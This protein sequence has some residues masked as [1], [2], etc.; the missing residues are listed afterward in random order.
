MTDEMTEAV[1]DCIVIGA[2]Y[3]GLSASKT[4]EEDGKSILLLEANERVGGR[5]WT[6]THEDGSWEDYGGA[7]LGVKQPL[8]YEL[9]SEFGITT[10]DVPTKGKSILHYR[11]KTRTQDP[12]GVPPMPAL[13]LV[14]ALLTLSKFNKLVE[15]INI[16]KPWLTPNA[17]KLDHTTVEEWTQKQSWSRHVKDS[18]RIGIE[19]LLGVSSSQ[20]S[21][22]HFLW[23]CKAGISFEV[24][25]TIDEGAQ[26]QLI[27][28]GGQ[29]IANCMHKK[30]GDSVRLGEPVVAVDQTHK[31][32]VVVTTTRGTYIG[33]R[34]IFAIP[35]PLLQ[36]IDF[37]PPLP[38]QKM[39]LI[40]NSPMG[41]YWKIFASY[42]KPFWHDKGLRGEAFSP[43]GYLGLVN[44]YSPE[45]RSRG[46]LMAFVVGLKAMT[47]ADLTNKQREK[48][49]LEELERC[50][51]K[52]AASPK[53]LTIH[54][55]MEEKY[56]TGCPVSVPAPGYVTSCGWWLRKPIDRIYW[57]G[58]ETA[59]AWCGYMEGAVGS[60]IRAAKEV[61]A[62]L[63]ETEK[64][65][66]LPAEANG[67]S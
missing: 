1:Y 42:D 22:L 13:A 8:M 46:V 17:Q 14:D 49:A 6:K 27:V 53:K 11:G 64:S 40:Q 52:E 12:K 41:N 45:D 31:D 56:L 28:G 21:M 54:T 2:G 25:T 39:K 66:L 38:I 44:D 47:F 60:G 18:M 29:A 51:G 5:V 34:V 37:S 3:A 35:L 24:L 9:A 57:A 15:T 16:E 33:K 10:F 30:L 58:T 20:I 43:D 62:T 59:T 63:E 7:Y 67:G 36:R 19:L 55:M 32:K 50:F 23:Y 4:L 48:V 65:E 61:I 26:K